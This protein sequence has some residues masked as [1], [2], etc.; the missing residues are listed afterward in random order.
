M[1]LLEYL[2]LVVKVVKSRVKLRGGESKR[3]RERP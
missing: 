2:Y 3:E 1:V